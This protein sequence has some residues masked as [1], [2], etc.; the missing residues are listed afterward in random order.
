[1]AGEIQVAATDYSSGPRR[2]TRRVEANAPSEIAVS[3]MSGIIGYV[4]A[5]VVDRFLASRERK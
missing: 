5:D 2:T 1:M 3:L 4:A